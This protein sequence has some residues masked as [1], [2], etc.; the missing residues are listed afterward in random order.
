MERIPD[1][2]QWIERIYHPENFER[3][4]DAEDED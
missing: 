4:Q 3:T 2:D 1:Y